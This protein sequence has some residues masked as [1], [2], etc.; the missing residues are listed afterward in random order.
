VELQGELGLGSFV[1]LGGI[2]PSW[3]RIAASEESRWSHYLIP[4]PPLCFSPRLLVIPDTKSI[5]PNI[6]MEDDPHPTRL[7]FS[8]FNNG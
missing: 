6:K 8:T 1:L 3:D 4:T 2:G 7:P 5:I